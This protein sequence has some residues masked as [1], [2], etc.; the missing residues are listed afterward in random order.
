MWPYLL[1]KRVSLPHKTERLELADGDFVDLLWVNQQAQAPIVIVLHGLEG[2]YHS[3]YVPGLLQ[4]IAN[5]GMRG[6]LMHFR[7]CSG[8]PNRLAKS[9][10][11]GQTEDLAFLVHTLQQREPHTAIA[12]VGISVGGN[13]LL[14]W[15]GETGKSNPLVA[16]VAVS[17]PF[18][19][20]KAADKLEQ[21]FSRIYQHYLLTKLLAKAKL[22]SELLKRHIDMGLINKIRTIR[23]FDDWLT[24][25]VHGFNNADHYYQQS[26]SRQ[27]LPLID[28]PT[29]IVHAADD[30]FMTPDVIPKSHELSSSTQLMLSEKGGHVGFISAKHPGYMQYHIDDWVSLFLR[31]NISM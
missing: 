27:Y 1:R 7:G 13:V 4:N 26:S 17:V 2:T 12:A 31:K 5:L 14:K 10:H 3:H 15:L 9:Y 29:L 16:A 23:Q 6:V 11:S 19:L 8:E 25:P 24:A 28:T 18:E 30:P 21:G 22:K 20:N